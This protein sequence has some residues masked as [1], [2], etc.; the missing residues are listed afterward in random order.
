MLRFQLGLLAIHKLSQLLLFLGR[1]V[2]L[3]SQIMVNEGHYPKR[4]GMIAD[5][6]KKVDP[7][8]QSSLTS[9]TFAQTIF[10]LVK[11][12]RV[13]PVLQLRQG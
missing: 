7:L 13:E 12:T 11:Q 9:A 1:D 2:S 4:A 6:T 5:E 10:H 8:E 3:Q